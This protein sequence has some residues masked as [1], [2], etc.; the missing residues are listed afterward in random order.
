MGEKG[1]N[2]FGARATGNSR[3]GKYLSFSL[4]GEE[5]GIGILKVKAIIGMMRITPLPQTPE[6][7]KRR[8]LPERKSHPC[9]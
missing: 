8:N 5:Y 1:E 9:D 7:R 4:G 6:Y 3:E 2:I